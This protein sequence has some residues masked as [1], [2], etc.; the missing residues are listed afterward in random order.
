MSLFQK[1]GLSFVA[2][3]VAGTTALA[4]PTTYT[5]KPSSYEKLPEAKKSGTLFMTLSNNPKVMNPVLSSDA[6]SSTFDGLFFATLFTEDSDNLNPLPYL[7]ESYSV[8]A[9]RKT[10]TFTLN[11]NAKW[12]DGT[13]V[14]SADVKYTF[15]TIMD[16]KTDAAPQRAYW[17]GVTLEVKDAHTIVFKVKEPRFDTLRTLYLF[18]AIQKKQFENEKNFN[19]AKDIMNPI[20]NGPFKL[21]T[22]SRDQRVEIERN[23]EWWGNSLPHMKARWNMESIVFRIIPDTNIT[24]E[25]FVKGEVD[26]MDFGGPGAE[27]FAKR[28]RNSDKSKIADKPGTDKAVWA[29]EIE[30]KAP[31]GFSY[32]GWNLRKPYFKSKKTRQALAH[33]AD[34]KDIAEKVFYGYHYQSSSP[35][36]SLT[37][38]S[39][40]ELRKNLFRYDTKKALELLKED[41]WADTD[42]DGVLDKT[43]DGKKTPFKFT[44]KY[45]SNNP[46]RGKIAQILQQN[47]RKA[48]IQ[49]D[50][51][52]ME[53]NAYLEDVDKREFDAIVMG[54]TATPYPNPRQIWHTDSE[55][56]QGSNFVSFS[57]KK[58][59]ELIDKANVETDL[60]K[61]A[62]I[63]QEINRILYD[64]QPYMWLTE[65]RSMLAGFNKKLNSPVWAMNY[66]VGPPVDIYRIE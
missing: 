48:G 15:D 66:D 3:A 27:I 38:N 47:F 11:K 13:P 20:G 23:K 32:V 42:N 46:A 26:I 36:G 4:K 55:K 35:F 56:D 1:V 5:P 8:S 18:T 25:R 61:R 34:V 53:W 14:T 6:N 22:F 19:Q 29:T 58:V 52:S 24:Y 12:Q 63:L 17:Q 43:I 49:I 51:R 37:M 41:G 57:N 33:L 10:Y 62:K 50:I 31:R 39:D 44:L 54:W 45:N 60:A 30:N 59:D 16:P 2:L 40:A 7:A 21:K 65:P 9:D 64:E 28:V